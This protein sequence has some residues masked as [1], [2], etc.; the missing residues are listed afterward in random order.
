MNH[1]VNQ[2]PSKVRVFDRLDQIKPILVYAKLPRNEGRQMSQGYMKMFAEGRI[3]PRDPYMMNGR[4]YVDC[5]KGAIKEID[6]YRPNST[7]QISPTFS[8]KFKGGL[9]ITPTQGY[10]VSNAKLKKQPVAEDRRSVMSTKSKSVRDIRVIGVAKERHSKVQQELK[11]DLE[12]YTS[13][14]DR[15]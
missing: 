7:T 2:L 12:K 3:M 14:N 10:F 6:T 9:V 8:K 5:V 11:K 13:G 4:K 15:H 1:P